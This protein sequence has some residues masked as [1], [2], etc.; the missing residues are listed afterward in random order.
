MIPAFLIFGLLVTVCV[1]VRE[2]RNLQHQVRA[3]RSNRDALLTYLQSDDDRPAKPCVP[4]NRLT[5]Y[6]GDMP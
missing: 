1:L 6:F 3:L 2:V 5:T 4:A